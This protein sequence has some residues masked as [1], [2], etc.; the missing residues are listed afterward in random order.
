MILQPRFNPVKPPLGQLAL[1]RQ[2]DPKPSQIRTD[3]VQ[4]M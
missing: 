3:Q 2:L 1:M 4:N